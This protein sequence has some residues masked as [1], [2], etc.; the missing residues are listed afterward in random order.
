MISDPNLESMLALTGAGIVGPVDELSGQVVY[1]VLKIERQLPDDFEEQKESY[2]VG[3]KQRLGAANMTNA[4]AELT[5]PDQIDWKF[6]SMRLMYTAMVEMNTSTDGDALADLAD[7]VESVLLED[8][9]FERELV[10][11][12]Y[13]LYKRALPLVG[14]ERKAEIEGLMEQVLLDVLNWGDSYSIQVELANLYFD[15]GDND[16]AANA[17]LVAAQGLVSPTPATQAN[18]DA[19]QAVVSIR[20]TESV[21]TDEQADEINAEILRWRAEMNEYQAEQDEL[22][23]QYEEDLAKLNEEAGP[24]TGEDAGSEEEASDEESTSEEAPAE[25]SEETTE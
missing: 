21:L 4:L 5:E 16:L 9:R 2:K 15:N 11:A 14:A 12:K 3:I 10:A 19:L 8:Q 7:E 20:K 17:L 23:R 18:A 13:Q 1:Q 22:N 25:G 6:E 24:G